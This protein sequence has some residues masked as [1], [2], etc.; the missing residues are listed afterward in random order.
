MVN[1]SEKRLDLSRIDR[2]K[3]VILGAAAVL[4][5]LIVALC[6]TAGTKSNIQREYTAARNEIGEQLYAELYMLC[7]TFDQV[8]VPGAEIQDV[9]IPDMREYYLSACTLNEAL[10]AGFGDRY[11][12]L[13]PDA[14]T[15][16]DAAFE[17]YDDAFR[18]GQSTA[19]A[20][21]SMRQC[22]QMLRGIL[23]SRYPRGVLS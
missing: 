11:A 22:V 1:H 20:E 19:A 12:V 13:T 21:E 9:I 23:D 17:A 15:A 4:V 6:I 14:M 8:G 10:T 3:A 7:Q 18:T 5:V 2:R 16:M